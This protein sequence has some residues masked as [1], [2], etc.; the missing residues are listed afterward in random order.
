M[1][2]SRRPNIVI[3]IA[4]DQRFAALADEGREAVRTPRLSQLAERGVRCTRAYHLGSCVGAVCAPSRA[5]LH[6]GRP[7]FEL[8]GEIMGPTYCEGDTPDFP[9]TLGA[10]LRDLGYHAFATG[11]WHNGVDTFHPSFDAGANLFFGGMADH[12]FTPVHDFDPAGR[13]PAD[14]RRVADGFSTEVFGQSAIDY[15]HSREGEDPPFL[16]YC[17]FTAPHDPRTPPDNYRR[18]YDPM[19]ID[20]PPNVLGEH[21]FD[22]GDLDLRDERLIGHPRLFHP[23]PTPV[24]EV[25]RCIAEYYGMISHMDHWIGRIH[26]AVAD[27]GELDNTIIVHTADHG[28]A[29]GQHGLMGKQNLYDHSTRVPLIAAGPGIARGHVA[30]GLCYQHDLHPTLL[31]AA[32]GDASESWFDSLSPLWAGEADAGRDTL[33]A[34]YCNT[35][36]M[37]RDSR[38]KLI[39]YDVKGEHREQLFDLD[40]DPW[41]TDDLIDAPE[42]ADTRGRLDEALAAWRSGVGDDAPEA[43]V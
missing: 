25:R 6:T 34:A 13:Y 31:E 36:R 19:S 5:M 27:I 32:G 29:L 17:A 12:W 38:H 33:G 22:N 42:H 40:A 23:H 7:Y 10:R 15:I 26:D 20:L 35:Q 8:P 16:C 30:D 41:E 2:S 18:L 4:D 28:L 11:K 21:P 1:P 3:T 39:R 9:R 37:I 43:G 14:Q 24:D